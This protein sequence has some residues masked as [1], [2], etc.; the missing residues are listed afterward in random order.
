MKAR[1][2]LVATAVAIV[3]ISTSALAHYM[4]PRHLEA[5][6][7]NPFG[8]TGRVT[9]TAP[10]HHK[11]ANQ[12]PPSDLALDIA[13][14]NPGDAANKTVYF[15]TAARSSGTTV[16]GRV[17]QG[18]YDSP[19]AAC[20]GDLRKGTYMLKVQLEMLATPETTWNTVGYV[21]YAHLNQPRWTNGTILYPGD[22]VG[23][24][25]S[26]LPVD[27]NC[28]TAPHVH[29][30]AYDYSHYAGYVPYSV[31]AAVSS[32][33]NLACVGGSRSNVTAC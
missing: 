29:V 14:P 24:V 10:Q 16:R 15:K 30:E 32:S 20:Y 21:I 31:N 8:T 13:Y 33:G 5:W 2:A 12:N 23:T 25:A 27:N 19:V 28:W 26:G 1:A 18:G 3:T 4:N 9:Q 22:S 6:V 17:I 11:L 7:V